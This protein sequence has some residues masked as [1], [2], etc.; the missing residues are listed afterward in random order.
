MNG[1]TA[2]NVFGAMAFVVAT[3]VIGGVLSPWV[4][5]GKEGIANV[6]LGNVLGWPGMV[7]AY[8]FGTTKSSAAK[9]ATISKLA[10]PAGAGEA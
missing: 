4:P 7:L 1:D 8:H 2:R 6:V 5:D 9:D 3:A 10:D